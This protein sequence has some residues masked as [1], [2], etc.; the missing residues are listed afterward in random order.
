MEIAIINYESVVENLVVIE[1]EFLDDLQAVY[2]GFLLVPFNRE[3]TGSPNIGYKYFADRNLFQN[4]QEAD[5]WVFDEE[6]EMWGPPVP[7][8]LDDRQYEWDY[9]TSNWKLI[10]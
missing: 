5:F 8:P 1:E 3:I 2:S 4:T 7:Y 9:E 6:S 10:S